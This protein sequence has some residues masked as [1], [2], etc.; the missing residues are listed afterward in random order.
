MLKPCG[1]VLWH[2]Q[3]YTSSISNQPLDIL[4]WNWILQFIIFCSSYYLYQKE[5]C[6]SP[7]LF[8]QFGPF[9]E[10][11]FH[12][13]WSF[14]EV[15]SISYFCIWWNKKFVL[16]FPLRQISPDS[17]PSNFLRN[18]CN[19]KYLSLD[20]RV[21]KNFLHLAPQFIPCYQVPPI[22]LSAFTLTSHNLCFF[23]WS[24]NLSFLFN[25][26][27]IVFVLFYFCLPQQNL[28]CSS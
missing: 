15:I 14:R 20:S 19:C 12:W 27:A 2:H 9:H 1:I 18:C 7:K 26:F 21:S 25:C 13:W 5:F 6:K 4:R 22:P 23:F 11:L 3:S 10:L 16:V 28:L 17:S 24:L 8:P